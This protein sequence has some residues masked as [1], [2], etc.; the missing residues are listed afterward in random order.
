[1][2]PRRFVVTGATA[3]GSED[4]MGRRCTA[5]EAEPVSILYRRFPE[6]KNERTAPEVAEGIREVLAAVAAAA[7]RK[8]P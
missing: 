7:D 2:K 5:A 3:G 8:D 4:H 1:M 6:L